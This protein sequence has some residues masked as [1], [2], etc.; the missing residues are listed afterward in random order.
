MKVE[1]KKKAKKTVLKNLVK[2]SGNIKQ[3]DR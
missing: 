2:T 3:D 1:E